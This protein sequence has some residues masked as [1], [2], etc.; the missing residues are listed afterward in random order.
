[1]QFSNCYRQLRSYCRNLKIL[2]MKEYLQLFYDYQD[3]LLWDRDIDS[4]EDRISMWLESEECKELENKFSDLTEAILGE[5][6]LTEDPQEI[7]KGTAL[8]SIKALIQQY[9][10]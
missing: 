7:S 8:Q 10:K 9:K 5:I 6:S 2:T 3:D 4:S 1:M